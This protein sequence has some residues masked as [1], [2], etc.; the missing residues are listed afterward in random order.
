[1]KITALITLLS[2]LIV[3]SPCYANSTVE[4]AYS[5]YRQGRHQEAVRM[6]EDYVREN[7]DPGALYLLGYAYYERGD[8]DKARRYFEDAYLID[9]DFSPSKR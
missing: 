8:L 6:L 9:P 5:L 7:P 4:K 3:S 1:M 2:L